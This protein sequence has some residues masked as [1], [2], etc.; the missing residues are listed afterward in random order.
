MKS[1]PTRGYTLIEVIVVVCILGVIASITLPQYQRTMETNRAI[2][3]T[4]YIRAAANA[5]KSYQMDRGIYLDGQLTDAC[6][7]AC[8]AGSP[9]CGA[10]ANNVCNLVAC[11]YMPKTSFSNLYW[12]IS[13]APNGLNPDCTGDGVNLPDVVACGKR[14]RCDVDPGEPLCIDPA[15]WPFR[16]W[17]YSISGNNVMYPHPNPKSPPP[18][19]L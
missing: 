9:G 19:P 2:S 7:T 16:C 18:W 10:A 5:N 6:N 1:R 4:T 8:C 17:Q 13:V 14:K 15:A 12:K 11:G 3:A